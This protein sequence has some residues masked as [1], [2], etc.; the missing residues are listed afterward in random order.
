[1]LKGKDP[2]TAMRCLEQ[3]QLFLVVF[4]NMSSNVNPHLTKTSED[5]PGEN[6]ASKY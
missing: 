5:W 1:M 6:I 2:I 4:T 3:L